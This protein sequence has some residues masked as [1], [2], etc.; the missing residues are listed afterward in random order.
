M[1]P[2][3][4]PSRNFLCKQEK[5]KNKE[6]GEWKGNR[7]GNGKLSVQFKSAR[8]ILVKGAKLNKLVKILV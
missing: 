2:Q 6:G 1:Y 4:R 5:K 3:A 7:G 8:K